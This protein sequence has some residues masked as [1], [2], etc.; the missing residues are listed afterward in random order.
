MK[1][2]LPCMVI[3]LMLTV[4]QTSAQSGPGSLAKNNVEYSTPKLA[5]LNA[6]ISNDRLLLN[7]S[8]EN[9]KVTDRFE[10]ERSTDGKTFQ[11]VALVFGSEQ[12]DVADYSFFEKAR[13][14]KTYYRLKMIYT[15]NK[16]EYSDIVIP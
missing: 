9:N 5:Y 2:I 12:S 14:A 4:S 7:W 11:M 10:V 16:A 13:K 3:A 1:Y 8:V 6:S 15:N